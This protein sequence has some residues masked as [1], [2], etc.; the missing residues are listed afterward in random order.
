MRDIINDSGYEKQASRFNDQG[1]RSKHGSIL[2]SKSSKQKE[3][4]DELSLIV[5][6]RVESPSENASIQDLQLKLRDMTKY[7]NQIGYN[8]N[9]IDSERLKQQMQSPNFTE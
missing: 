8:A 9:I 7:I 2:P 4:V 3:G 1:D 6:S 5:H